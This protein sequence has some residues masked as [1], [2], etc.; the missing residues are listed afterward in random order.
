MVAW[1][2]PAAPSSPAT[3]DALAA[4]RPVRRRPGARASAC[5]ADAR[6]EA[7]RAERQALADQIQNEVFSAHRTLLQGLGTVKTSARRLTAA[8]ASYRVR[9]LLFQTGKT[10]SVEL[11][12][13]QVELTRARL[14]A[15]Y[16]RVDA[17][18]AKSG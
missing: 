14:E 7:L 5:A 15:L 1:S 16:A 9:R 18:V 11:L 6:A 12:D 2:G 10:T 13:A 4:S 17:R 8:E 3:S